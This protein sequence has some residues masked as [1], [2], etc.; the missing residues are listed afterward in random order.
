VA[1]IGKSI[2]LRLNATAPEL[3]SEGM[4]IDPDIVEFA[5]LAHD[6]GHP[7]FGYNR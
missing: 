6:L 1:Q 7:P 4:A 3:R 2:A 5:G